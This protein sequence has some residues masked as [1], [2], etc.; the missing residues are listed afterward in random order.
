MLLQTT[1]IASISRPDCP[2]ETI[3][4]R[5][6]LDSGSQR[7]YVSNR[8]KNAINLSVIGT[9]QPKMK[10]FGNTGTVS[11]EMENFQFMIQNPPN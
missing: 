3:E 1:G 5:M 7:Y 2:T 10:T 4:A 9:E 8:L 11:R 6:I